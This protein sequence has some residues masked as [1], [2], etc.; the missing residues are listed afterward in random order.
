MTAVLAKGNPRDS[1]YARNANDWYVEPAE[2]AHALIDAERFEGET[3]DPAC[4][5]GN[6]VRVFR[7]RGLDAW[8]TDLVMRYDQMETDGMPRPMFG[9]T[10]DFTRPVPDECYSNVDNIV[11]NPPFKIAE[12][13]IVNGLKR[14][15]RKVALLQRLAFLEG[16]QRAALFLSSPLARVHV[17]SYRIS[18]PPGGVTGIEAKGGSVA[19]AWFVWEH[20]HQGPPTINWLTKPGRSLGTESAHSGSHQTVS[21]EASHP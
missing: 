15:R 4:G 19:F 21:A 18:M 5:G 8:G 10:G 14:A 6:I 16:Q 3:L 20:G 9:C 2:A 12:R 1:G 11:S 17:F 13:F 7:A